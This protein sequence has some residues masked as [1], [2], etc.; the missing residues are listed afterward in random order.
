MS[1]RK[2]WNDFI[3]SSGFAY[4]WRAFSAVLLIFYA[5]NAFWHG[6]RGD[7]FTFELNA[8][9]A[10]LYAYAMAKSHSTVKNQ[11]RPR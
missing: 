5:G 1:F 2:I 7:I 4:Y 9:I 11:R 8:L 10:G 6:L 3:S